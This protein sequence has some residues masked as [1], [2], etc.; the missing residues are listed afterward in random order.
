MTCMLAS[1][2]SQMLCGACIDTTSSPIQEC[3]REC[4]Q[5]LAVMGRG[6]LAVVLFRC[7][8][9]NHTG[10]HIR[11]TGAVLDLVDP[12]CLNALSS[13]VTIRL[14]R[15]GLCGREAK[16]VPLGDFGDPRARACM[17]WVSDCRKG[18][19]WTWVRGPPLSPL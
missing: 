10:S 17:H 13:T 4:E 12:R 14:L 7:E 18:E 9:S 5:L 6:V 15:A 11:V 1:H 2:K 19:M 3:V 16:V 8:S